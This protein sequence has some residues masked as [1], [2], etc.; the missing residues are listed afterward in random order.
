[1]KLRD[2]MKITIASYKNLYDC[3]VTFGIRKQRQAEKGVKEMKAKIKEL[4]RQ[5]LI[6]NNQVGVV[7]WPQ[8]M[9]L[10]SEL[11]SLLQSY[12]EISRHDD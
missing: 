1:M 8:K 12:D 2:E 11:A 3:S 4:D 7:D 9:D 5:K 10:T 6:L